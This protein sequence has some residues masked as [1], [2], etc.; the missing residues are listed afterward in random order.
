[1]LASLYDNPEQFPVMFEDWNSVLLRLDPGVGEA[2]VTF[3]GDDGAVI[4]EQVLSL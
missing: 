2:T 3:I 1:M 4:A